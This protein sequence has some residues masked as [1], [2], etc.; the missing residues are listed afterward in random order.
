[1]ITLNEEQWIKYALESLQGVAEEI[2]VVDGG[3][4]DKTIEIC[5]KFKN[6]KVYSKAWTGDYGAQREY[7][8]KQATGD[9]V[10]ILDSDEVL[11]DNAYLLKEY[12]ESNQAD[13]YDV[14]MEHFI[15]D[16]G[17]VDAT[18]ETHVSKSRLFR[19]NPDFKYVG[20]LHEAPYSASWKT[21]GLIT[22][23]VIFHNGYL[24]DL[25]TVKEKFE[26]NIKRSKIHNPEFLV[27]W[28]DW[29][30]KGTYPVKLYNGPYPIVLKE[31]FY[32]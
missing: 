23:V 26:M 14:K 2:I 25:S 24:K 20:D 6:V 13:V 1:M 30:L 8:V 18:V 7:S 10:F 12:A 11:S 27:Q 16:F 15:R 17:H 3:S 5:N 21:A 9:W 22:D 19:N 29:H 28:R 4:K 32:L 31:A